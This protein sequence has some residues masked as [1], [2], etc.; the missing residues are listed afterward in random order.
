MIGGKFGRWL[1]ISE[2]PARQP[3]QVYATRDFWNVRCD[4]GTEKIIRGRDLREGHSKS[5][6]CYKNE[7]SR[8]RHTTHGL[9]DS[10]TYM[11]WHSMKARCTC[12]NSRNYYNYGRRGVKL[13]DRWMKFDNFVLDM[14]VRPDGLTL[15]R[16]NPYGDYEPSNC[17]W[18]E[19]SEQNRNK[20]VR[21]SLCDWTLTEL[22]DEIDRR[23]PCP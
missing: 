2:S 11:V 18:V 10:P 5:C 16:I 22:I 23:V 4:C 17:R 6:G 15:D 20:R 19:K 21:K 13:C 14:G 8:K 12:I 7:L 1:V 9:C 3:Y